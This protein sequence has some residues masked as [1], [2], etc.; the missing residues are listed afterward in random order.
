M[1][2]NIAKEVAALTC[3]TFSRVLLVRKVMPDG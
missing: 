1:S 3:R 2:V